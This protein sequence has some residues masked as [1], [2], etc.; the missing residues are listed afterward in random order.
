MR[1][2]LRL[3]SAALLLL[4]LLAGCGGPSTNQGNLETTSWGSEA[5]KYQGIEVPAGHLK[6]YFRADGRMSYHVGTQVYKGKYKYSSG[7]MVIFEL[8]R[9]LA[10]SKSHTEK[11]WFEGDRMIVSDILGPK[12]GFRRLR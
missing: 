1:G 8:D 12:M 5:T 10:G 11:I 7:D 9:E 4:P 2:S 3:R 6:L